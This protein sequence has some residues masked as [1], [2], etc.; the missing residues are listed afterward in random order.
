[1][2]RLVED[3]NA[4]ALDFCPAVQRRAKSRLKFQVGFPEAAGEQ[5]LAVGGAASISPQR[6][7]SNTSDPEDE[8]GPEQYTFNLQA[9]RARPVA[10]Q[11]SLAKQPCSAA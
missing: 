11:V 1:M 4:H 10:K 2:D 9:L 6:T 3:N 5:A 8:A 7:D